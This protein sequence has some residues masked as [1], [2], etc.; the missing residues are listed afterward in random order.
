MS[1]SDYKVTLR[2]P[3]A[4]EEYLKSICEEYGLSFNEAVKHCIIEHKRHTNL[5]LS[6]I[7]SD[8]IQPRSQDESGITHDTINEK[9]GITSGII[10]SNVTVS[11]EVEKSLNGITHDT[12]DGITHDTI[13]SHQGAPYILYILNNNKYK[14][15][16]SCP[17]LNEAWDDWVAYRKS[18]R[19][20]IK[21]TQLKQ[22]FRQFEE[23]YG[24]EG[25]QGIIDRLNSAISAGYTGWYFGKDTLKQKP[26]T[27][28]HGD[29]TESDF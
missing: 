14:L 5:V 8:T 9:S 10:K 4:L 12:T 24:A 21:D 1:H 22:I 3:N 11:A 18:K 17:K 2:L 25:T 23:V 20:T 16:I 28:T 13:T 27:V 19:K 29:F 6:G 15:I 7:T 26:V